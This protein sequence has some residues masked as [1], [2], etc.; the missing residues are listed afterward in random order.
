MRSANESL[1]ERNGETHGGE[2]ARGT[3]R[4]RVEPRRNGEKNSRNSND[5]VIAICSYYVTAELWK[6]VENAERS[7]GVRR[8]ER[9][10][11]AQSL[12]ACSGCGGDY[13]DPDWTAW[14][15][16]PEDEEGESDESPVQEKAVVEAEEGPDGR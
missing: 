7:G 15:E 3:Q 11:K 6:S 10:A 9:R 2:V 4:A 13:E 16:D 8:D 12:R 5:R 1:Q 14:E